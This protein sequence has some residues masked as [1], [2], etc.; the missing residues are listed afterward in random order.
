MIQYCIMRAKS[1]RRQV[2][3]RS[4]LRRWVGPDSHAPGAIPA[5]TLSQFQAALFGWP[6][7]A[8]NRQT[9]LWQLC[10]IVSQPV[11]VLMPSQF[12][13][14][15]RCLVRCMFRWLVGLLYAWLLQCP[16]AEPV[17][18]PM[19]GAMAGALSSGIP[20]RVAGQAS[21][22]RAA[23]S[24]GLVRWLSPPTRSRLDLAPRPG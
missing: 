4:R 1:T 14:V 17:R 16:M 24:H 9:T 19:P 6:V 2:A 5:Q 21:G 22:V 3:G 20:R 23:R 10:A 15:I 12:C 8:P 11:V 18:W 13:F 7:T